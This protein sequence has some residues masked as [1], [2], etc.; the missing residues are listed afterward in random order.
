MP[1]VRSIIVPSGQRSEI[2]EALHTQQEQHWQLEE[3]SRAQF[4]IYNVRFI[5]DPYWRTRFWSIQ[6][7]HDAYSG[8]G[9]HPAWSVVGR[10][11]SLGQ[12]A[13]VAGPIAAAASRA[14]IA[15]LWKAFVASF[16]IVEL[17]FLGWQRTYNWL[18]WRAF[19]KESK[20]HGQA[21]P[22]R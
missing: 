6:S 20:R 5:H 22:S 9:G 3:K 21:R 4:R 7:A 12:V 14:Q 19:D 15:S 10:A 16:L 11:F 1:I 13:F 18:Y 17:V 2:D 8:K